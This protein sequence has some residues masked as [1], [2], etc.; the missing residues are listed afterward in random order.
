[1]YDLHVH[2]IGHDRRIKDYSGN[3]DAYV[4]QAELLGLEA[5]GFVDH[6]PYRM[7]NVQK[8]MEKINYYKTHA[9]IP[10]LYGA[11]IYVPSNTRIPKYF[12]FSLAH[13]RRGYNL[14]EAFKMAQQKSIDIIAH[15][16]AYG[17][18]CSNSRIEQ[19]KDSGIALELSEKGLLYFPQWLYEK[20]LELDIPLTLG[21]DAHNPEDMGFPE[22]QERGLTWTPFTRIPFVEEGGWL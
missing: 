16:C 4:L 2:V 20:A 5:L 11:E 6:Y 15:P 14:E 8:V 9:D 17:A 10:I 21:S 13:T 1:M 18:R 22:I 7:K 3:I 19:F 12:D